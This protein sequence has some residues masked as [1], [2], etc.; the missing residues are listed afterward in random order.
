MMD[1]VYRNALI[2]YQCQTVH[3]GFRVGIHMCE[4]GVCF[5][6]T[7][8]TCTYDP[9]HYIVTHVLK[10]SLPPIIQGTQCPP[11]LGTKNHAEEPWRR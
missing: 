2:T 7:L 8:R 1:I 5:A 9:Y 6:G 10:I 4:R 11:M 3:V